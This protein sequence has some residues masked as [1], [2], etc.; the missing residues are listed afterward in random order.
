M[1]QT[2]PGI[3]AV[4]P[5]STT[6]ARRVGFKDK[7]IDRSSLTA[8]PNASRPIR[9]S[10]ECASSSQCQ[11]SKG[12]DP[13]GTKAFQPAPSMTT[14]RLI[15]ARA[16]SR[17]RNRSKSHR[18]GQKAQRQINKRSIDDRSH[19]LRLWWSQTGSNRRPHACKA[20]ALPTELW[21][22]QRTDDETPDDR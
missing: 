9:P 12:H 1:L 5:E 18:K 13:S 3:L 19:A 15:A 17:E 11:I 4:K 6:G 10:T 20:R 8:C 14:P 2:H 7:T 22:R 21:P 16:S